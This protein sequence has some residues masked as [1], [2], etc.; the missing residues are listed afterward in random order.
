MST[1]QL[2]VPD[3]TIRDSLT[4]NYDKHDLSQRTEENKTSSVAI[5]DEDSD[6]PATTCTSSKAVC[7]DACAGHYVELVTRVDKLTN[8]YQWQNK[9][10]DKALSST[11]QLKVHLTRLNVIGVLVVTLVVTLGLALVVVRSFIGCGDWLHEVRKLRLYI[12]YIKTIRCKT[13]Y[14]LSAR[15][16]TKL[17]VRTIQL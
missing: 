1:K 4:V 6:K 12:L 10:T 15:M 11:S 2:T 8:D 5:P 13:Y 16:G 17:S 7:C 14:C 9:R 3:E